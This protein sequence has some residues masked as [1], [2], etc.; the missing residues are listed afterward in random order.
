MGQTCFRC[1][2]LLEPV[3]DAEPTKLQF[4][5]SLTVELSG[6][7]VMFIESG[8]IDEVS[9]KVEG[10]H[11]LCHDCAVGLFFYLSIEPDNFHSNCQEHCQYGS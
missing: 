2:T 5:N 8:W 3:F 6:G 4:N 11:S 10:P 7:Y 1:D 9:A